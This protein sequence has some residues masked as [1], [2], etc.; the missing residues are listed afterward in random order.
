M[1]G[2]TVG[3]WRATLVGVVL[4]ACLSHQVRAQE[5]GDAVAGRRLAEAW[6]ASCHVVTAKADSG[7]SDGAPSFA[8]IGGA[9]STTYLSMRAFLQTP[10]DRMPDL[11]LSRDEMDDLTAYLLSLR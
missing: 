7:I 5:I 1:I 2:R 4:I 6:C 9:K 8:A 3:R 10:H 11:H